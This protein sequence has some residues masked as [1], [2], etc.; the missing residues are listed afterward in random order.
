MINISL[1]SSFNNKII[2]IIKDAN[3]NNS[4]VTV[5]LRRK[6][7]Q[8]RNHTLIHQKKVNKIETTLCILNGS[9]FF[10]DDIDKS[11]QMFIIVPYLNLFFGNI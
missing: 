8:I 1:F 6:D 3:L 9:D 7:Y 10:L 4:T 5:F 2:V 11:K